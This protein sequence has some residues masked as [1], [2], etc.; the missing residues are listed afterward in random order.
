MRDDRARTRA[1]RLGALAVASSLLALVVYVVAVRTRLGQRIDGVAFNRRF[2]VT[3]AMTRRTDRLLGTVSV[4]SLVAV[5][6]ALVVVALARRRPSLAVAV[7]VAITG[8]VLT[9]EL[10][11]LRVLTRP[12]LGDFGGV[13]Y[14]TFP[15]GHATIGMVLSLGLV[16]VAPPRL[17]RAAAIV[18]ALVSTAFGT[19]VLSSG[20]HRPSDTIGAYLVSL[21]WFSGCS[22]V[23]AGHNRKVRPDATTDVDTPSSRPL[24]LTAATGVFGLLMFVLWKSVGVTGLRTVVF[25]A[26]YVAACIG[27]DA[28]GILVVGGFYVLQRS[29]ITR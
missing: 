18:A 2:A 14:N 9:T 10:L 12:D 5:G 24:L 3:A 4:A 29:S 27:I 25:A 21:A 11:K 28:A 8:A 19:A 1:P 13:E 15:S 17:G 7:G 6:L 20:W 26:P 23:L 22:A 16:L